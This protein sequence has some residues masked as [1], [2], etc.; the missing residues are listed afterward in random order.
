MT[1]AYQREGLHPAFEDAQPLLRQHYEEIAWKRDKIALLPDIERYDAMDVAGKLRVFT[2]RQEGTL[3]GYA[4]Y[5]LSNALHYKQTSVATNDVVF[6]QASQRGKM[7]G[8]R[9]MKFAD[10][11]LKMDGVQVIILHIK[12]AA[13]WG[14]MAE[15][16]GYEHTEAIY[17]RWLGD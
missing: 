1:I 6:L 13:N 11:A 10:A 17:Q 16:M 15:L 9:L 2:A 8:I 5:I 4:V 7:A 14:R 3:I 12:T